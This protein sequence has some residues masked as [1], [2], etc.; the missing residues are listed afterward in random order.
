MMLICYRA[1]KNISLLKK[2]TEITCDETFPYLI[3]KSMPQCEHDKHS[4]FTFKKHS[5]IENNALFG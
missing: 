4:Y 1:F 5:I 3:N 2:L